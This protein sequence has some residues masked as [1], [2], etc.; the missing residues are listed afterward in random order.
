MHGN[1][2]DVARAAAVD[3]VVPHV[4]GR[5]A[6]GVPGSRV[7]AALFLCRNSA[8]NVSAGFTRCPRLVV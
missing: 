2:R 8:A 4:P 5:A 7:C 1:Q 3:A 6:L